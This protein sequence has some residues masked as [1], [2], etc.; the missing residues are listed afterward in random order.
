M[1]PLAIAIPILRA[2]AITYRFRPGS[3]AIDGRI[4]LALRL[5]QPALVDVDIGPRSEFG[6]RCRLRARVQAIDG[7]VELPFGGFCVARR[8]AE[9]DQPAQYGCWVTLPGRTWTGPVEFRADA[10]TVAMPVD[11]V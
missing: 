10:A 1:T 9:A 6:E 11:P 3:A 4:R 5:A 7:E 8:L 2:V